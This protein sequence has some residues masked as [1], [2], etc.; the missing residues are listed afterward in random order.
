MR[1]TVTRHQVR[2]ARSGAPPG[3]GRH[4]LGHPGIPGQAQVVVTAELDEAAA[5]HLDACALADAGEIKKALG[6]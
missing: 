5:V 2:G 4:R 1:L 3:A 6:V